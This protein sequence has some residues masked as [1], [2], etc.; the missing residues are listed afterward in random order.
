LTRKETDPLRGGGGKGR[1]G[2]R[3]RWQVSA[4][5][6]KRR[7]TEKT[8]RG[9]WPFSV[10]INGFSCITCENLK[11]NTK[12]EEGRKTRLNSNIP[13]SKRWGGGN[14][15]KEKISENTF[16]LGR[17]MVKFPPKERAWRTVN[18]ME[19]GSGRE[20]PK[21]LPTNSRKKREGHPGGG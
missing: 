7:R 19:I 20:N 18:P 17:K 5:L 12:G 16:G 1:E 13:T 4:G 14:K 9:N 2:I 11:K 21:G 8:G 10:K 6:V 15:E 3:G